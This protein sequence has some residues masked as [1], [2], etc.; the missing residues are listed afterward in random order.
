MVRFFSDGTAVLKA[1]AR[2][3]A[4]NLE[5]ELRG[6]NRSGFGV[7]DLL[8]RIDV[9]LFMWTSPLTYHRTI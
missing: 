7:R 5:F 3:P 8:P 9:N 4:I 6:Q 2:S 1:E